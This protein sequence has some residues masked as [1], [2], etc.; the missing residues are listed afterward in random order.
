[1]PVLLK[2]LQKIREE[3][4]SKL[5]FEASIALKPKP[6]KDTTRKEKLQY[7]AAVHGVMKSQ[8]WLGD[9]KSTMNIGAKIHNKTVCY[10][11]LIES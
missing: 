9:W 7:Y 10:S 1:M 6:E 8:T 5:I 2:L 3:N 4:I 11:T